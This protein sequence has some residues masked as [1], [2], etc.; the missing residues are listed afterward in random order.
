[1]DFES[2]PRSGGSMVAIDF[3]SEY[4][5]RENA[6]QCGNRFSDER[7]PDVVLTNVC[8]IP[9]DQ[10]SHGEG[11]SIRSNCNSKLKSKRKTQYNAHSFRLRSTRLYS[12]FPR[13][14]KINIYLTIRLSLRINLVLGK[15]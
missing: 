4:R 6:K 9:S 15:H 10:I 5:P 11:L 1:M 12:I 2:Q 14:S 3:R 13:H 7:P 8:T